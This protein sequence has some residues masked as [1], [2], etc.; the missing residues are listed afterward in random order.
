MEGD[1]DIEVTKESYVPSLTAGILKRGIYLH[2][3]WWREEKS[4]YSTGTCTRT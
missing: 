3:E 2:S 4:L 1:Y